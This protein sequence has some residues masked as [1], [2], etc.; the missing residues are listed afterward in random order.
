MNT[1]TADSRLGAARGMLRLIPPGRPAVMMCADVGLQ[2]GP[3]AGRGS[4]DRLRDFVELP[5]DAIFLT[6]GVLRWFSEALLAKPE[7]GLV[8]RTDWCSQWR[9]AH[10]NPHL[11]GRATTVTTPAEAADA[12]ADAIAHYLLLGSTDPDVEKSY[13]RRTAR[14]IR[15]AHAIGLPVI[16]EPLIRGGAVVGDE[17]RRDFMCLAIRTAL[18]LGADALKIEAPQDQDSAEVIG[19]S[20]VPVL[21][22][23]TPPTGDSEAVERARGARRAGA[24]GVAFSADFFGSARPAEL[25]VDIRQAIDSTD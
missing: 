23:S 18:E 15:K 3:P 12:G 24:A 11:D 25:L 20:S 7:M 5:F 8:V 16:V 1:I 13:V 6:H 14:C 22:A 4:V 2:V 10:L 17:R 9:P 21:I 19:S